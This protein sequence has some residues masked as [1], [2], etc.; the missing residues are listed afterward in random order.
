M[1]S[2]RKLWTLEI[3]VDTR[4]PKIED[5]PIDASA[6]ELVKAGT[7]REMKSEMCEAIESC[8]TEIFAVKAAG[9]TMDEERDK[10]QLCAGDDGVDVAERDTRRYSRTSHRRC[11]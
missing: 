7:V 8:V 3:L 5:A 10:L 6:L 11:A 9:V 2:P 1:V 4:L